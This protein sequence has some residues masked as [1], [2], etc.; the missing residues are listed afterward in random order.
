MFLTLVRGVVNR[1]DCYHLVTWVR[2]CANPRGA[3]A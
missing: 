1:F 3:A 2:R